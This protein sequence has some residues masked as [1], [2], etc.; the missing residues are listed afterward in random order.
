MF[1]YLF[2]AGFGGV[3]FGSEP[4]ERDGPSR[5]LDPRAGDDEVRI[6]QELASWHPEAEGASACIRTHQRMGTRILVGVRFAPKRFRAARLARRRVQVVQRGVSQS[7]R[8]LIVPRAAVR[9]IVPLRD[10]AGSGRVLAHPRG[11]GF[12]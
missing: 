11:E 7:T 4:R 1:K 10:H 3:L 2:I 6:L 5:D 12:E 8:D 9:V